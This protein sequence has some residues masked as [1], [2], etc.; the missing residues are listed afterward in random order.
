MTINSHK[1]EFIS[2]IKSKII[3]K[4]GKRRRNKEKYNGKEEIFAYHKI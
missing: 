3:K 2:F 1:S 4:G